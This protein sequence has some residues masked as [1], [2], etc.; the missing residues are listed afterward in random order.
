MCNYQNNSVSTL[1]KHIEERHPEKIECNI[2]K[3]DFTNAHILR[4]HMTDKHNLS[5]ANKVDWGL[6]IGDS[7]IKSVQTRRLEKACKGGRLRNPASTKPKTG[8]AYTTSRYW[9]NA[10][11]PESNLE[12]RVPKLLGERN[13][14]YMITLTPSN[15]IKNAEG[16]ENKEQFKMAEETALA[17]LAIV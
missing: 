1:N 7:H 16:R 2:C 14:D 10:H 17:T 4:K 15:N 8:S 6:I 12:D 9:P 5:S 13:Y 3:K 11:F